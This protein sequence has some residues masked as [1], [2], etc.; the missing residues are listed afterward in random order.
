MPVL[1]LEKIGRPICRVV[2][3]YYNNKLVSVATQDEEEE[4]VNKPFTHFVA[5][6][7]KFQ[8]VPD[9]N[10]ERQILYITGASGSGKSTYCVSFLKE[11]KKKFKDH[12]IYVFSSLDSD[13]T[14]DQISDLKRIIIDKTLATDPIAVD[15]LKN[16]V[17]VFD[18][19]DVIGDKATRAAVY[20]LLNQCLEVGRHHNI[21][22]LITNHLATNGKD[23]RRILNEAHTITYFPHSGSSH[24]ARYLLEKYCGLDKKEIMKQKKMKSRW[25]TIFKHYPTIVLSERNVYMLSAED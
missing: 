24:G 18:D 22:L 19:V 8:Q 4:E 14:L 2:G 23:T 21:Y 5:S 25:V 15:S 10:T 7:G 1:N 12:P 20:T 13:E 6:E 11:Y 17:C 9:P 16:S 3:G